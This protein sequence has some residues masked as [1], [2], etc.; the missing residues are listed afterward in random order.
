MTM[1]AAV[2]PALASVLGVVAI[3]SAYAYAVIRGDQQ[4]GLHNLPDITHCVLKQPERGLFL[5][6]FMPAC[7]LMAGSWM[8]GA[9]NSKTAWIF[10]VVGSLLLVLGE[11]ML[12]A[13]PNWT[14]HT[15]GASGFF[16]CTMVAQVARAWAPS[17]RE[18]RA[19]LNAKRL[20]AGFNLGL[21]VLDGVLALCK[22]PA[23][24]PNLIEWTLSF[25]VAAF[26]ATFAYDLRNARIVLEHTTVAPAPIATRTEALLAATHSKC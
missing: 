26:H 15:I 5:T 18:T 3:V 21:L 9:P 6:I 22:A 13:K 19:S 25:T 1:P 14:I 4:F 7:M 12:D 11:A 10:G 24:A 16:L 17:A 8:L 2:L 20:I 23:W